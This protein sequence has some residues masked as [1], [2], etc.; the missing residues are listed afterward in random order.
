[1]VVD[2]LHYRTL[3]VLHV[4]LSAPTSVALKIAPS[5]LLGHKTG[6]FSYLRIS[7]HLDIAVNRNV[8]TPQYT[9]SMM[10]LATVLVAGF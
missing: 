4:P 7:G 1:M 5:T 2:Q 6:I 8:Y 3:K 9:S 10:I